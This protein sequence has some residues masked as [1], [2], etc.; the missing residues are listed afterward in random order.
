MKIA[1]WNVNSV[2]VRLP[3]VI[4]WL[5]QHRPAV[6]AL[7]ETKVED[8]AFPSA[9]IREV[10]YTSYFTGQKTYNGVALLADG[11]LE[12]V[13]IDG[14]FGPSAER[15]FIA[16]TGGGVRIV[17]VYVPNGQA[18]G[19]EKYDQKLAWLATLADYLAAQKQRYR[20]VVVIGD[21][22]VALAAADVYDPQALD[23]SILFSEPER[24]A[25]ARILEAGYS[26]VF[27]CFDQPAGSYSWWDYRAAA[28]RR[29]R[30]LRIDLILASESMVR[31][32][33]RCVIDTSMRAHERPSDHAPVIANFEGD[34][35]HESE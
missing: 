13:D 20:D 5:A 2:R 26:D 4:D 19:A 34:S 18:V 11:P 14:P 16:A 32:C 3:Q 27:R 9:A 17:N 10:G 35:D 25:V 6:L 8:D 7:Q 28:F 12:D 31:R 33:R 24:Q 15:R 22:N 1:T 23:G 29:N 30:G 21:F